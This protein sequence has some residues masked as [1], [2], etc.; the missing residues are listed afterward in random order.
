IAE[1][2]KAKSGVD[3][4]AA[5]GVPAL[6]P[7]GAV[8]RWACAFVQAV[9]IFAVYGIVVGPVVYLMV[10]GFGVLDGSL[11]GW[12]A[13]EDATKFSLGIWPSWLAISIAAK[14]IVIGRYK[15]GRY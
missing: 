10:L 11:E 14:W 6:R 13:A 15:P 5:D 1:V 3:V 12:R 2:A 7:V 8:G 4:L 9:T